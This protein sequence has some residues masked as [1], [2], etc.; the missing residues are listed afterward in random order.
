MRGAGRYGI[1]FPLLALAWVSAP[2]PLAA[3]QAAVQAPP[4]AGVARSA[5]G[6]MPDGQAVEVFTLTNAH[7]LEA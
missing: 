4:R 7:G 2:A 3:P 6:R 5:F 1:G